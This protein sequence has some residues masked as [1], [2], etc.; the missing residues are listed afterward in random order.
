MAQDVK[1]VERLIVKAEEAWQAASD[2]HERHAT[3]QTFAAEQ[4]A[5]DHYA[6]LCNEIDQCQHIGC[7]V[8]I[9]EYAY[10]AAHRAR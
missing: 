8:R 3:P 4:T 6:D 5:W 2:E 9:F 10:C 7:R 1:T